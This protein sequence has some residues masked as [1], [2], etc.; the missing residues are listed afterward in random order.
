MK[1]IGI[2]GQGFVGTAI[3]EGLKSK[4]DIETYDKFK[5]SSCSTL[6]EL[7]TKTKMFLCVCLP[8]CVW[9]VLAIFP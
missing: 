1:A 8:Q 5:D 2:I 3:R 9:T 6:E 7:M 4:F